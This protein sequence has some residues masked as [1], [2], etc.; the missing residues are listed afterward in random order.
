MDPD[1]MFEAEQQIARALTEWR[2]EDAESGVEYKA[3]LRLRLP[4]DSIAKAERYND[5]RR[6]IHLEQDA[7]R[8]RLESFG[9]VTLGDPRQAQ[10]W[11]L[12]RSLENGDSTID[13]ESFDKSVRPLIN[14][15]DRHDD[16]VTKFAKT[17]VG[18]VDRVSGETD[19]I[20]V[21]AELTSKM[22]AVLGWPE[23]S[24]GFRPLLEEHSSTGIDD[25]NFTK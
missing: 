16:S 24:E 9:D 15:A 25:S 23:V 20:Q 13:W 7:T 19:Q 8:Q 2:T 21:L 12:M 14:H 17:V 11:W 3:R 5:A 18:L 1:M 6:V 22:A 4:P 10:L